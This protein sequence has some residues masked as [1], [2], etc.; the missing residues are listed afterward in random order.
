M[1]WKLPQPNNTTILLFMRAYPYRISQ[2]LL[3]LREKVIT[4]PSQQNAVTEVEIWVLAVF[5]ETC[6]CPVYPMVIK[7]GSYAPIVH[8]KISHRSGKIRE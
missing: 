2:G 6:C 5:T 8:R 3:A 7:H 1:D 4:E